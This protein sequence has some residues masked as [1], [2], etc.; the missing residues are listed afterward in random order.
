MTSPHWHIQSTHFILPKEG[1]T[2]DECEDAV[3][4]NAE[5]LA[6]S[7]ADG[8]T[9]AFDA[10]SWARRLAEN[11]VREERPPLV[12]EEFRAWVEA[13]GRTLQ[14]SW[15]ERGG[16]LPW[17]A[18]EKRRAGSFAAFVGLQFQASVD[19]EGDLCW[20]VVALGDSCLVRRRGEQILDAV[21]VAS[22][23][24]FN[25][26]PVLVP[27]RAELGAATLARAITREGATREGDVF[28]LLT[29]AVAAWYLEHC[30]RGALKTVAEFDSLLAGSQNEEVAEL[31]RHERS[32]GR[33]KDDDVAIIRLAVAAR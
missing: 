29:D 9:E 32:A 25:S 30:E 33:M 6:Y 26:C 7:I 10:G 12:V 11:W 8:A 24:D 21:P 16:A 13:Q 17:Y 14:E 4:V 23:Q 22:S 2:L 3:A 1:S 28:L 18:E 5:T 20:R 19:N 15:A 31:I 27:S